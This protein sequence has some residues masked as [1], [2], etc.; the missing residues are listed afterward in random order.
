MKRAPRLS[1]YDRL[2]L[3]QLDVRGRIHDPTSVKF[4]VRQFWEKRVPEKYEFRF[5]VLE[6]LPRNLRQIIY[7]FYDISVRN[8]HSLDTLFTLP[9]VPKTRS[10]SLRRFP[11]HS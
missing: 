6:R 7:D 11:D 4:T 10:V 2:K 8:V 1:H 5:S 3:M 9:H